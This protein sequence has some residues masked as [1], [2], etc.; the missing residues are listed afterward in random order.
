MNDKSRLVPESIQKA[1]NNDYVLT[2]TSSLKVQF[3]GKRVIRNIMHSLEGLN[4]QPLVLY[5]IA[6]VPNFHTNIMSEDLIRKQEYWH[7]SLNST[8]RQGTELDRYIIM[9]LQYR[10]WLNIIQ[11]ISLHYCFFLPN[12][13]SDILV[14]SAFQTSDS[15]PYRIEKIQGRYPRIDLVEVWHQCTSYPGP[16]ILEYTVNIRGIKIRGIP[17]TQYEPYTQSKVK[18]QS[19]V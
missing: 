15:Q 5:D 18:I 17:T 1:D 9:N 8:V 14:Y 12:L 4:S 3:Q 19:P 7:Y 10:Y 6:I 2:R 16:D 11:Y 13:V